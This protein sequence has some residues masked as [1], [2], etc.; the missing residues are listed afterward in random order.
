MSTLINIADNISPDRILIEPSGIFV[1]SEIY[2][3]FK[4]SQVNSRMVLSS[5]LTVIDCTKF[6]K[7]RH[8]FGYFF[9]NQINYADKLILS[10][11]TD[12]SQDVQINII[13]DLQ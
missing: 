10:K 13:E 6:L 5:S 8:H 1:L 3:I 7:Q 11:T 2:D 9:E 4:Y 12:I